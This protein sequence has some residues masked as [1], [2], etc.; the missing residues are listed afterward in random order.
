MCSTTILALLTAWSGEVLAHGGFQ[1][2]EDVDF[3]SD[4]APVVS[5]TYGLLHPASGQ[6]WAWV[7]EEAVSDSSTWSIAVSTTDRWLAATTSG[8]NW[9]D[10]HCD[11]S[12]STGLEGLYV[13][14][15]TRDATLPDRIWATTSSGTAENA[16]WVSEDGGDSFSAHA[17]FG[18]EST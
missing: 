6:D 8:L 3:Q 9:T 15:V 1:Q 4:D 14:Q 11:W 7:C 16:V 2:T 17:T 10:D 18:D 5:T 13:T 12:S